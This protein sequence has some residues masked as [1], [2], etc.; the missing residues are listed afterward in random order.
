[1]SHFFQ[2]FEKEYRVQPL[3]GNSVQNR[4][5]SEMRYEL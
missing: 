2:D 3:D 1:M 4:Q 5:V